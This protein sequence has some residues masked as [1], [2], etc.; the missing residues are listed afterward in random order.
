MFEGKGVNRLFTVITL[1]AAVMMAAC[2]QN[3]APQATSSLPVRYAKIDLADIA[4]A[5]ALTARCEEE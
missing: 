4:T 1:G 2:S 3:E 5:E